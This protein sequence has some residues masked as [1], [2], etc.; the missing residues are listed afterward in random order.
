[1]QSP[2]ATE[3]ARALLVTWSKAEPKPVQEGSVG[4]IRFLSTIPFLQWLV[5]RL[6]PGT[7]ASVDTHDHGELVNALEAL[8]AHIVAEI[9]R[10]RT[11]SC[12]GALG[13]RVRGGIVSS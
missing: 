5:R 8:D 2:V 3:V 11:S 9:Q 13:H 1:M 12:G 7:L 6:E 4:G 10:L